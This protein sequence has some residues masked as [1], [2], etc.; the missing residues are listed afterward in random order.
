MSEVTLTCKVNG[1]EVSR[2][3]K[4]GMLL[5]DFLRQELGLTGT[6]V[7]C[8]E[9]ECGSCAVLVD[10][11]PVNSCIYPAL[12]VSGREVLTIEGVQDRRGELDRLQRAFIEAGASQCGFCTPGMIINAKALLAREPR[13]DRDQIKQALSGVLCRCTGY[14]KIVEAVDMAAGTGAENGREAT[15]GQ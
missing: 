1:E 9:G 12:K 13:P 4:P 3:I 6:K 10:G 2:S 14:S 15:R 8:R 7:G 5:V 11:T